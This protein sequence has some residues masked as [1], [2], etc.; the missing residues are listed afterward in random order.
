MAARPE[1]PVISHS[2]RIPADTMRVNQND[3]DEV[4]YWC[5]ELQCTPDELR[6]AVSAV[7]QDV[8]NV[9]LHLSQRGH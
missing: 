7:G 2:D 1:E 5:R 4:A 3:D 8:E 9:R 6:E